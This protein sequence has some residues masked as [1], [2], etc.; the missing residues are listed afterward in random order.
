MLSMFDLLA[1][2]A[3]AFGVSGN[4]EEVRQVIIMR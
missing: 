1:K 4:E 2:V 3:N